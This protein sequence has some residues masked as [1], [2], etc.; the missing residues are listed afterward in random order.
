MK[1]ILITILS[2]LVFFIILGVNIAYLCE[3]YDKWSLTTVPQEVYQE[4]EKF[5]KEVLGIERIIPLRRVTS[6]TIRKV[7]WYYWMVVGPSY[8]PIIEDIFVIE[9]MLNDNDNEIVYVGCVY[10][11]PKV[12]FFSSGNIRKGQIVQK[13]RSTEEVLLRLT[14]Y[15][16]LP[17]DISCY[18]M[19]RSKYY[20]KIKIQYNGIYS[21]NN[22]LHKYIYPELENVSESKKW[23]FINFNMNL[24]EEDGKLSL[25]SFYCE[26]SAMGDIRHWVN[27]SVHLRVRY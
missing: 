21:G 7:M 5:I 27:H 3:K 4:N 15:L 19:N 24:F 9:Y 16:D 11:I 13:S 12:T 20:N 1:K 10:S 6:R 23:L 22:S 26:P 14:N 17:I 2:C 8:A 18:H 25:L